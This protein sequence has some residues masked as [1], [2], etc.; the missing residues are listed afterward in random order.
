MLSVMLLE[1]D[2]YT[3]VGEH[4]RDLLAILNVKPCTLS[5]KDVIKIIKYIIE[6]K[7]VCLHG[8]P[9]SQNYGAS[10]YQ[11]N[12]AIDDQELCLLSLSLLW[13]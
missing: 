10:I 8:L 3:Y 13:K 6:L 4:A 12:D 2:L 1:A 7:T 5:N 9:N 11:F